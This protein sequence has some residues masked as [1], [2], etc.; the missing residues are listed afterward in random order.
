MATCQICARPIKANIGIIAHHGY[1]R[2]QRN[3]GWQTASCMG[4]RHLPYEESCDVLPRAIKSCEDFIAVQEGFVRKNI[5]TPP[6]ELTYS[7]KDA[8]GRDRF[9]PRELPR[10]ENFNAK[11]EAAAGSY[12]PG[13]YAG[14]FTSMI[15]KARMRATNSRP[16]LKFLQ[17]RL[18]N[19]KAPT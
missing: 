9:P 10:P 3:S 18:A 11:K 15:G 5:A 12:T 16:T 14:E 8:Y 7:R 17:E 19:W 13:T 6:D 4:A 2:P 1:R